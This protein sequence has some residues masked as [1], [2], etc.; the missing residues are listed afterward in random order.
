MAL[1]QEVKEV[2]RARLTEY[3]AKRASSKYHEGYGVW[4]H[5]VE[6]FVFTR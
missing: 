2:K 4:S 3:V 6:P 1:L 5:R